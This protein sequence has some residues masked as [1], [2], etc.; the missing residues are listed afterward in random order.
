MKRAS[1]SSPSSFLGGTRALRSGRWLTGRL[2]K[3][4]VNPYDMMHVTTAILFVHLAALPPD[5]SGGI[6]APRASSGRHSALGDRRF[7]L[8]S[9]TP[10]CGSSPLLI[11]LLNVVNTTGNYI[12]DKSLT[13]AANAALASDPS[14]SKDAF[15]GRYAADLNLTFTVLG[16]LLQ[17]FAVSRIV[18]YLGMSGVI[19]A[20]PLVALGGYGLI[21]AGAGLAVVEWTKIAEN[22]TDYS[23]MNTARQLVW[24]PTSRDEKY[25]AKQAIDTF[26]VRTGDRSTRCSSSRGPPGLVSA[27][28]VRTREPRPDRWVARG[29][30]SCSCASTAS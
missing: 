11:V 26:F 24:L 29:R 10:T 13:A 16:A 7:R 2:F 4:G 12:W 8:S 6:G 22:A 15:I 20:L 5:R 17:A 27:S 9:R 25:K 28:R 19:L 3:A 18:K 30:A 21:A 14:L 1:G 23:V